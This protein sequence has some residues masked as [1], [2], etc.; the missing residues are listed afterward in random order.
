MLDVDRTGVTSILRQGVPGSKP[1]VNMA[2]DIATGYY[3]ASESVDAAFREWLPMLDP[4]YLAK[5]RAALV[6]GLWGGTFPRGATLDELRGLDEFQRLTSGERAAIG[7]RL[8]QDVAPST[9]PGS[10]TF[11]DDVERVLGELGT[12][13]DPNPAI[14]PLRAQLDELVAR[15]RARIAGNTPRG[16]VRGYSNHP[17]YAELGRIR[18]NLGLI[19]ALNA[20]QR[21]AAAAAAG[22]TASAAAAAGGETLTW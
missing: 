2:T 3:S 19:G 22:D 15:N 9:V 8:I 5:R 1:V 13:R 10:I 20:P 7:A 16:A 4:E 12:Q 6:E 18:S 11:L 21:P 14:A 17:D